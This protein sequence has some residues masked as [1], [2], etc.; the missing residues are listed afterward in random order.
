[1]CP[2]VPLA[3]S[4]ITM[5]AMAR[6]RDE[7]FASAAD[8]AQALRHWLATPAAQ[9]A[10]AS[11]SAGPITAATAPPEAA[12]RGTAPAPARRRGLWAA[13]ALA[14]LLLASA[15]WWSA[16]PPAGDPQAAP[17]P[18]A[19]TA[20]ASATTAIE[21]PA[22]AGAAADNPAQ[23][24]ADAGAAPA[25]S[26]VADAVDTAAAAPRPLPTKP[27][28]RPA[29]TKAK[30]PPRAVVES[31][32]PVPEAPPP[33]NGMVHIAISPWG[34]VEVDGKAAGTT[35]PLTR[36]ELSPGSHVI[37]VR[38]ADFPPFTQSVTVDAERPVT[39][40]HRFGS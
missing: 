9:A 3:L 24:T 27:A 2:E 11:A 4:A 8:M 18:A 21:P 30:K 7:R 33:A 37:T 35:P 12:V 32:A 31:V 38:N 10:A 1:L 39:V 29:S 19:V 16:G 15:G 40:K 17:Q 20:N 26:G 13:V 6:Q 22:A 14:V 5:R 34:Q 36:L 25:D 28:A 23:V